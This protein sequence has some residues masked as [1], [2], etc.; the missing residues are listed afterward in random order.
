MA[1]W[2]LLMSDDGDEFPDT[3]ASRKEAEVQVAKFRDMG[4]CVYS[5]VCVSDD[6]TWEEA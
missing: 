4:I 5:I 1:E 2:V 6:G 3:F